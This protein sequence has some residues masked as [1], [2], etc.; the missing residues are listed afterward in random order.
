MLSI[1]TYAADPTPASPA[2]QALIQNQVRELGNA[3]GVEV[4]KK[5]E[6]PKTE[7]SEKNIADVADRALTMVSDVTAQ[8][9]NILAK[10]APDVW[11]IMIKQQYAKAIM[12]IIVPFGLLVL[13][14]IYIKLVHYF[15][16]EETVNTDEWWFRAWLTKIIPIAACFIDSIWLF[17]RAADSVAYLINP[18]YYAIQDLLRML[19]SHSVI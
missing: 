5:A 8:L 15:W 10:V 14:L 3:F 19:L 18:E 13:L 1:S 16:K 12:G 11:K 6:V 7:K 2:D 9:S 4:P 17:N